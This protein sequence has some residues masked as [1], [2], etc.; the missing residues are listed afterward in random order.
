MGLV[1]NAHPAARDFFD[2]L[3]VAETVADLPVDRLPAREAVVDA[4]GPAT[5]ESY[6]VM[7]GSE[8]PQTAHAACLLPDGRRTWANSDDAD[9]ATDMTRAE[10]CAR[11][12]TLDGAGNFTP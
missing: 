6:T 8:G 7:Y 4:S 3:I 2:D 9:L 10:H 11:P 12:V 1:H 5:I